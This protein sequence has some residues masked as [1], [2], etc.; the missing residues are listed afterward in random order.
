MEVAIAGA[1]SGGL[2]AALCLHQKGFRVQVKWANP[3]AGARG[4]R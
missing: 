2:A 3:T 1:G 4:A